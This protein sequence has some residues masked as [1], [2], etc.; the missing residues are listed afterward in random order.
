MCF[1]IRSLIS[2]LPGVISFALFL[3]GTLG[4]D[5]LGIS[6]SIVAAWIGSVLF[7]WGCA[8]TLGV[9]V[10]SSRGSASIGAFAVSAKVTL[11]SVI[12][13]VGTSVAVTGSFVRIASNLLS[14][15]ICSNPFSLLFPFNACVRSF[16]A[17]DTMSALVKVGCVIYFV[18]KNT[19]SDTRSLL[20]C[21]T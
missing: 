13:G 1:R 7:L 20:V 16:S 14:A 19:V 4:S 3:I 9:G 5:A 15:S 10:V 8:V 11:R 2:I 17:F 6:F 12:C 21:L 18:L